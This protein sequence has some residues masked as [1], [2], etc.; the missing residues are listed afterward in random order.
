[1][2]YFYIKIK[3]NCI[4]NKSETKLQTE[5]VKNICTSYLNMENPQIFL[6]SIPLA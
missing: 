5:K 1:M 2:D 4:F 6:S 3:D